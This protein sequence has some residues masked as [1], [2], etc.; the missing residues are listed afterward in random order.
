MNILLIVVQLFIAIALIVLTL[1]QTTKSEGLGGVIG[2]KSTATFKGKK[3]TDEIIDKLTT[4]FAIA[5]LISSLLVAIL[6]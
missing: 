3:T 6:S 2:G 5:F 1:L 4:I